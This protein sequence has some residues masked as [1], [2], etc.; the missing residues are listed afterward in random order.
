M[1][2][3]GE[4]FE[5]AIT[6]NYVQLNTTLKQAIGGIVTW[7]VVDWPHCTAHFFPVQGHSQT[8][9][10]LPYRLQTGNRNVEYTIEIPAKN[11]G[12]LFNA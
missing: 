5:P 9:G 1:N 3:T 12:R 11:R 7:M 8:G 10:R 2:L 6:V 4:E